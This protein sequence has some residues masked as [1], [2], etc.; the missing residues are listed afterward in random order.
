MI[1]LLKKLHCAVGIILLLLA[2]SVNAAAIDIDGNAGNKEWE[3]SEVYNLKEQLDFVNDVKNAVVNIYF[4][5][6]SNALYLLLRCELKSLTDLSAAKLSFCVNGSDKTEINFSNELLSSPYETHSAVMA[7]TD[8]GFVFVETVCY[9]KEGLDF[10]AEISLSIYD[11]SGNG[12]NVYGI[13][14]GAQKTEEDD[15]GAE[16]SANGKTSKTAKQKSSKTT[17]AAKAASRRTKRSTTAF[18]FSRAA[19]NE[20]Q[21]NDVETE[22]NEINEKESADSPDNLNAE[23]ADGSSGSLPLVI[24]GSVCAAAVAAAAVYSAIKSNKNNQDDETNN[25][26]K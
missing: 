6:G 19:K 14:Y 1:P 8:S 4:D 16:Q 9:I 2:F 13:T 26:Q 25:K 21:I 5:S 17:K 11:S 7:D 24:I 10:P 22:I 20:G 23:I 12:S 15:D 18:P 3:N